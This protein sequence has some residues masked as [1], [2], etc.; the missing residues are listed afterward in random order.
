M[1]ILIVSQYFYPENFKVNDLAFDFKRNGHNVTVLTGKP[2][3]PNGK[4]FEGYGFFKN[5]KEIIKGVNIIRVPLFPRLNGSGK[6]LILNYFSFIFFTFFAVLFRVK[7]NFDVIF[8]HLPSP[9]TSAIP[10]IW[11]K[12]KFTI[13]FTLFYI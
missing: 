3:Y 11:L 13:G 2:N 1:K 10:G 9:L 6:F 8:S 7:G 4:F 5:R 12:K